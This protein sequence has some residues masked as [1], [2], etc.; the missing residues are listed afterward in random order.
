[1]ELEVRASRLEV[2]PSIFMLASA[3]YTVR[4]PT[5]RMGDHIP[6]LNN[7]ME[8]KKQ[9]TADTHVLDEAKLYD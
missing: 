3:Q 8:I 6:C 2:D 9:Y 7:R 4:R 5:A 1:M